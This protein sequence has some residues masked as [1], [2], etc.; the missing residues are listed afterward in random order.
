MKG[1]EE[2]EARP[3]MTEYAAILK[4]AMEKYEA[5]DVEEGALL[6][7]Q[8]ADTMLLKAVQTDDA[9]L[10]ERAQALYKLLDY[11]TRSGKSGYSP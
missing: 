7:K 10:R 11:L 1:D 3:D 8:Q 2:V 6:L 4:K 5:G 9:A